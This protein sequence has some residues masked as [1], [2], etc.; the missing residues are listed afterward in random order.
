MTDTELETMRMY[1]RTVAGFKTG[2]GE[3][4]GED[5]QEFGAA[6]RQ[7]IEDG[8]E[9]AMRYWAW[10]LASEAEWIR[11]YTAMVRAAEA[12]I[13]VERAAERREAA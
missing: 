7:V 10:W 11:R 13:R 12:R 3:W 1:W 2:A 4:T 5:E 9:E 6:I 8:C